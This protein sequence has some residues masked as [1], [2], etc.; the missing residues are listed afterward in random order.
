MNQKFR[1][2]VSARG[3]EHIHVYGVTRMESQGC[4]KDGR[5][6]I[7][8]EEKWHSEGE[9]TPLNGR[10]RKGSPCQKEKE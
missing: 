7:R 5:G 4:H 3:R 10:Q 9:E 6:Y 2:E 1:G 8:A